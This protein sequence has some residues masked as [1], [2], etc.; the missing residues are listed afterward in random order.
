MLNTS[1]QD[2]MYWKNVF[3]KYRQLLSVQAVI[4][5][6]NLLAVFV[7]LTIKIRKEQFLVK[8]VEWKLQIFKT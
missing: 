2:C 6:S 1:C 4:D 5:D 7:G 3:V 8:A